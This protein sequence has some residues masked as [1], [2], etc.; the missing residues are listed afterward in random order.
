MGNVWWAPSSGKPPAVFPCGW[1]LVLLGGPLRPG[2]LHEKFPSLE[3]RRGPP[4]WTLNVGGRLGPSPPLPD[5]IHFP[6]RGT[7]GCRLAAGWGGNIVGISRGWGFP[8]AWRQGCGVSHRMTHSTSTVCPPI[9]PEEEWGES[10]S[11]EAA[12]SCR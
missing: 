5:F 7:T 12:P 3:S 11:L 6:T 2:A 10:R 1:P 9:I 4:F 8:G